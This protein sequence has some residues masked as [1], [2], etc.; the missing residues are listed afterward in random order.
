MAA[1]WHGHVDVGW[2]HSARPWALVAWTILGIG[3]LL[4]ANWAYQ[5]LGWGGY[6]GWDPVEN[7][8]LLPWLTGTALIH[9]LMAWRLRGRFKKT[10]FALAIATCGLCNFSAFLTRSGVFSSVHAFSESPIGWM[11]LALMGALA[12]S[13]AVLLVYRRAELRYQPLP[14]SLLARETLILVSVFMLLLLTIVVLIG[15]LVAPVSKMMTG[16]MIEVG[17]AFYNSV[18][19]PI[20]LSLLAMTAAVPLLRWGAPPTRRDGQ[21]LAVCLLISA[22][23][24]ASSLTLGVRRPLAL[25]VVGLAALAA[26]A[27][28]A[29]GWRSLRRQSASLAWKSRPHLWFS[30]RRKYAAYAIHLGFVC[31]AIGIAGSSLGTRRQEFTL[32][33]GDTINW[34]GRQVHY[35]R[36]EQHKLPDKLV[37]EAVMEVSRGRSAPVELRP[38]RHFHL[39]Q[40][41]WTT[42]VAIQSTWGGD[43]YTILN[44]GLGEGRVVITLVS[45]PMMRWIWMGGFIIT[46]GAIVAVWPSRRVRYSNRQSTGTVSEQAILEHHPSSM[47]AA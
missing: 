18:L 21:L 36:L 6:W 22:A 25:A 39:L 44:A 29:A 16:R 17:P 26:S 13:A 41:E 43:F 38:G 15:T 4:G 31:V 27:P 28:L 11:F 7:G 33:E 40:N 24:A 34:Q 23:V 46:G 32:A 2:T 30:G 19:P 3:L 10:A 45:N 47:C 8:S 9:C 14:S 12:V 42:E 1:L 20:G 35:A 37:A 5:E